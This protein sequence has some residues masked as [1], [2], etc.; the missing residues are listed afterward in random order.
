MLNAGVGNYNT[1]QEAEHYLAIDRAF[2]PDMVILECFI[3]DAEPAPRERNAGLL[4]H[5][6]LAAFA[7]SRFDAAL[8][9]ANL[10]PQWREYYSSLYRDGN[11]GF[12]AEKD[13]FFRLAVMTRE[14]QAKLLVTILPELHE[15]N[16]DYPFK[17]EH[18]K[19]EDFL[20]TQHVPVIDLIDGLRGH[21]P[22]SSLWI[23][24]ADDHP[25]AKANALIVAQVIQWILQ[26]INA[27]D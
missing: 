8:R 18:R 7:F 15:I 22:E 17:A 19:I 12:E 26:N 25:N 4:G 20:A 9:V 23:T 21:G 24:P 27:H 2:H 11:P 14:D 1:V 13:A 3:N 6:Y 10:C 5:S 16:T